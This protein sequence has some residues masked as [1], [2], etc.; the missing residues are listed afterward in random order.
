MDLMKMMKK[1]LGEVKKFLVKL[2]GMKLKEKIFLVGLFVLF[3]FAV[4]MVMKQC[5]LMERMADYN[6]SGGA[7]DS[8]TPVQV[9]SG[10]DHSGDKAKFVMYS[11]STCGFCKQAKPDFKT[12]MDKNLPGVEFELK[13]DAKEDTEWKNVGGFPT[14]KLHK[15]NGETE[16]YGEDTS[17][18]LNGECG[19]D[20]KSLEHFCNNVAHNN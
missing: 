12:L 16:V 11:M 8:N 13:E 18:C 6:A 14:F 9:P 7:S 3:Y 19:R 2:N 17:K 4:N 1:L 5:G 10:V 15:P 20:L